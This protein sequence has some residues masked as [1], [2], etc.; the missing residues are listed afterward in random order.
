[1][2]IALKIITPYVG[3]RFYFLFPSSSINTINNQHNNHCLT[4]I[5][6]FAHDASLKNDSKNQFIV[7]EVRSYND[8]GA[9][10]VILAHSFHNEELYNP[11]GNTCNVG[12]ALQ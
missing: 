12:S 5:L 9:T 2:F 11:S 1:M 6:L 10:G 7:S 4:I 3:W 8:T